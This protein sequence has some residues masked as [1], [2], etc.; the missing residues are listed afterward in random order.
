MK[1]LDGFVKLAA[2]EYQVHITHCQVFADL[3]LGQNL[4]DDQE[5][6]LFY[7]QVMARREE[8]GWD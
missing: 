4:E 8:Q 6:V 3:L 2:C 7:A 1:R 5:L